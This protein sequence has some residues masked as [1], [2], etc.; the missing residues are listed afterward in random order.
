[1]RNI[2]ILIGLVI[3]L[4]DIVAAPIAGGFAEYNGASDA[5][6]EFGV[7]GIFVAMLGGIVAG[8]AADD[9]VWN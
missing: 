3:M 4:G 2:L 6:F 5:F 1:M 7:F 8:V 9:N